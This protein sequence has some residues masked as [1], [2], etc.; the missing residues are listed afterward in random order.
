[1]RFDDI[2]SRDGLQALNSY[3]QDKRYIEG[4]VPSQADTVVFEALSGAPSTF[5][6]HVLRWYKHITS[7]G[8]EKDTFP[9]QKKELT[10]ILMEIEKAISNIMVK[11]EN[12]DCV[13]R[14]A[15]ICLHE[16]NHLNHGL[17]LMKEN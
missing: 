15:N 4:F 17:L 12:I 7:Y 13:L 14:D 3:L 11:T 8:N 5:Y 16:L 6:S 9:G 10:L 1:M 2:N